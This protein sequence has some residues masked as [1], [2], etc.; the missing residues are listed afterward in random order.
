MFGFTVWFLVAAFQRVVCLNP[1]FCFFMLME[2]CWLQNVD[3]SVKMSFLRPGPGPGDLASGDC[4]RQN[5]ISK[6]QVKEL[7]ELARSVELQ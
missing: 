5:L 3:D 7:V 1:C 6:A 4:S 2:L